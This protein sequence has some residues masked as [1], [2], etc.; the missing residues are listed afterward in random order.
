MVTNEL[1]AFLFLSIIMN[2]IDLY[3]FDMFQPVLNM[4]VYI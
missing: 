1:L 4:Y 2:I 3:C